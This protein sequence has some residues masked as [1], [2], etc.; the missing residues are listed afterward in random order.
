M[1]CSSDLLDVRSKPKGKKDK[2]IINLD[3]VN[4]KLEA[5]PYLKRY[6]LRSLSHVTEVSA[7]MLCRMRKRNEIMTTTN[8]F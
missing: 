8:T 3:A 6:I 1:A 7:P 5:A 4:K 2:E